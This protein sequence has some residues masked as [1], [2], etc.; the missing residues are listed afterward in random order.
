MKENCPI[1][2]KELPEIPA[3][4]DVGSDKDIKVCNLCERH[5]DVLQSSANPEKLKISKRYFSPHIMELTNEEVLDFLEDIYRVADSIIKTN[6]Q[7]RSVSQTGNNQNNGVVPTCIGILL[8]IGGIIGLVHFN[9]VVSNPLFN[10]T[11]GGCGKSSWGVACTECERLSV[12]LVISIM[13][14]IGGVYGG[15]KG[16]ASLTKK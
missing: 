5:I 14:L 12:I 3:E 2:G 6:R 4:Y 8:A 7:L 11:F 10:F 9:G 13:A 15:V 16:I 1:C